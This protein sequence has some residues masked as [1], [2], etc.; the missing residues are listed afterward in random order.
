MLKCKMTRANLQFAELRSGLGPE[1][2][3]LLFCPL[4]VEGQEK[5]HNEQG[6][7]VSGA[8]PGEGQAGRY[9]SPGMGQL[10]IGI[11]GPRSTESRALTWGETSLVNPLGHH[12]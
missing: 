12:I 1:P 3:V 7:R 6:T 4:C 9:R 8:V 2:G 5:S 10:K 11:V